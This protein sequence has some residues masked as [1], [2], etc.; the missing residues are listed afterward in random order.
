MITGNTKLYVIIADPVSTVRTP[1]VLNETFAQSNLDAV[2][3]PIQISPENLKSM[4]I[5][6]RSMKNLGGIIVSNPHK[7]AMAA[8]CDEVSA[9]GRAI[10][11]VNAIRRE[12][13]RRLIADMFDGAGF[14]AGMRARRLEPT[15]CKTLL[16][17]GGGAAMAIAFAL[18]Q[19]GVA[20]LA[21]TNPTRSTAQE[22]VTRVSQFSPGLVVKVGGVDP[23]G[24]DL[25]INAIS[26]SLWAKGPPPIDTGLL[27]PNTIVA[28]TMMKP[29]NTPL[30]IAA[31]EKGCTVHFGR[32]MLDHQLRLISDFMGATAAGRA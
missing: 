4:A 8:L 21:V 1:E 20:S 9:D 15:G 17:G 12:A 11:S 6:F 14:I 2:I 24:Y 28:E 10:G 13:D 30:L 26:L 7:T 22:I 32:H 18:A 23:T 5:A 29:P 19:E 27:T 3:V 16:I 25:V 31:A